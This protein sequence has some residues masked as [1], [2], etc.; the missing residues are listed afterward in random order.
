MTSQNEQPLTGYP[1]IDRPWMKYYSDETINAP[2]PECTIYEYMVQNNK[3]YPSD[4]AIIYLGKKITYRELFENID[5]T[6]A[7]F[8]KAGVKEKEIVTVALSSI[9]EAIYCVYALDKIGAVANMIHPLVGKEETLNYFNEVQSRIAVIF[10]GAY[11]VIANDINKT[12]LEKVIVASVADSLPSALKI[13]YRLKAK[14][15]ALDEKVFASWKAFI[16]ESRGTIVTAV[17]KDCHEMAIISHTGGTTGEPKG[18]MCSDRGINS[19]I[20]QIVC[21]FLYTRQKT[22]LV[23]LPPFVNYSLAEAM[24]GMLSIGFKVALLPKY[25]SMELGKYIKKYQ[26]YVIFSIP[27]YWEALLKIK[28]IEAIDISCLRYA[29]YGGEAMVE[30]TEKAINELL[31]RC[32]SSGKLLK[33]VGSTE[34]MAAATSTYEDCNEI[35]SVGIPLVL[36][37]CKIV[38]PETTEELSYNQDGEICFSGPT[39]MLGYYNN[40]DATNGVVKEHSDGKLWLHTGDLGYITENGLIYVTGRIKRI[41]MTKDLNGQVTKMFPDRIERAIYSDPSVELCCV[42]G[43]Q[44]EERINYPKAFVVLRQGEIESDEKIQEIIERC[45]KNLPKYMIPI[46]IEFREDLPRTERGKIDYRVLEKVMKNSKTENT[47][48]IESLVSQYK[49]IRE[50]ITYYEDKSFEVAWKALTLVA[51]LIGAASSK[52]FAKYQS[53]LFFAV[54][55]IALLGHYQFAIFTRYSAVYQGYAAGLEEIINSK[56][57]YD[58]FFWN[59]DYI[60][61]FIG[62]KHFLTN[63]LSWAAFTPPVLLPSGYSFFVL[64]NQLPMAVWGVYVLLYLFM[65]IIVC[66][67]CFINGRIRRK[68]RAEFSRKREQ[69]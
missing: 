57:G 50:S 20:Y 28:N 18:V 48:I 39:L 31:K 49:S 16:Q 37:N 19:L 63:L 60:D 35:G 26:P 5:K 67:D 4:I 3:D 12:S 42:V 22:C 40:P 64:Y 62:G 30:E 53:I 54:P 27:A 11:D 65:E 33:G 69:K 43:I 68:A 58:G 38:E 6:A 32:G 51:A 45:H 15:P 41:I 55:M 25:E 29:I 34:M 47:E 14:Q 2:L 61:D 17:K 46:E 36:V 13:T 52:F 21:N 56:M 66:R 1:S 10:D 23:V 59:R 44:D 8:L 24:L 9:P 7:A